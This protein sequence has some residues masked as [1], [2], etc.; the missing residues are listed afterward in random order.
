TARRTARRSCRGI[1]PSPRE[2]SS[3]RS[4]HCPLPVM[5]GL[6]LGIHAFLRKQDVDGWVSP[7]H[8]EREVTSLGTRPGMTNFD[9]HQLAY[10]TLILAS[11]MT[12]RH[13]GSSD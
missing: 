12:L 6:V 11:V 10:S 1:V 13:F 3:Y 9:L 2:V 5:P 7:G 4:L 8:D